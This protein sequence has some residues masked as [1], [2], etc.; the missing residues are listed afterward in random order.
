MKLPDPSAAAAAAA[1]AV[2]QQP[3]GVLLQQQPPHS[4][5]THILDTLVPS[6]GKM[7]V[8]QWTCLGHASA[9]SVCLWIK[10]CLHSSRSS[11]SSFTP[12]Q[13]EMRQRHPSKHNL[14]YQ[15]VHFQHS[16]APQARMC[17]R[18]RWC[19]KHLYMLLSGKLRS[20]STCAPLASPFPPSSWC[21]LCS[22]PCLRVAP[23]SPVFS[24]PLRCCVV[25]WT[26]RQQ[27][28]RTGKGSCTSRCG[29]YA[30]ML[31]AQHSAALHSTAQCH[32]P[33]HS[34]ILST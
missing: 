5:I 6:Y 18:P 16:S 22:P 14:Q 28:T 8:Q 9:L 13:S 30:S 33:Q 19:A 31:W 12:S 4:T 7:Q 32:D 27:H 26:V 11:S 3:P 15:Y 17:S 2:G 1:S 23:V 25:S 24:H 21:V 29:L 20:L 34:S 10:L